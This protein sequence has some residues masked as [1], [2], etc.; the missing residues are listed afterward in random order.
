MMMMMKSS[1]EEDVSDKKIINVV[2]SLV[3][4]KDMVD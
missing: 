2:R 3:F 1:G 4:D